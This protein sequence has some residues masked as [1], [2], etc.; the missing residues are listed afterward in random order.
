MGKKTFGGFLGTLVKFP[1][2][3]LITCYINPNIEEFPNGSTNTK[4]KKIKR[5]CKLLHQ[6]DLLITK[7]LP[8]IQPELSVSTCV[9]NEQAL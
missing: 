6:M 1:S 8:A 2:F 5:V 9:A 7:L 4:D 3:D